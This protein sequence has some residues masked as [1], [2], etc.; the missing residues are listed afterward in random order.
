M[1]EKRYCEKK[2]NRPK[3]THRVL[4]SNDSTVMQFFGLVTS[5]DMSCDKDVEN[6]MNC[7]MVMATHYG[8]MKELF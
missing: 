6:E 7:L 2:I 1:K 5:L 8:H 3:P 4:Q